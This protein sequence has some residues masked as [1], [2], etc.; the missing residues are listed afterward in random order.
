MLS[1][2]LGNSGL[3]TAKAYTPIANPERWLCRKA[4]SQRNQADLTGAPG[5]PYG[6][7]N[8]S[9]KVPEVTVDFKIRESRP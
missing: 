1:G 4:A 5:W 8:K 3:R 2:N 6:V 9:A 7:K